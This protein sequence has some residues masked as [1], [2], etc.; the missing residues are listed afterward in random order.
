M[1]L[2]RFFT[3]ISNLES[4]LEKILRVFFNCQFY[5]KKRDCELSNIQDQQKKHSY[6]PKKSFPTFF[7]LRHFLIK[8]LVFDVQRMINFWV[9][10]V[11][12]SQYLKKYG[13]FKKKFRSKRVIKM[14]FRTFLFLY[15][16]GKKYL[17][18]EIL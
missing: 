11:D 1:F 4:K 8:G 7:V 17:L 9:Q 14:D 12:H 6:K 3:L 15:F 18:F 2:K 13:F 16:F 10:K 5:V